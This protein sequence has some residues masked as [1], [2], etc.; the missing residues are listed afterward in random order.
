MTTPAKP[1]VKPAA[2]DDNRFPTLPF[3]VEDPKLIAARCHVLGCTPV[4]LRELTKREEIDAHQWERIEA[5]EKMVQTLT[6]LVMPKK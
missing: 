6:T 2:K 1:A 3:S 5:L 4:M